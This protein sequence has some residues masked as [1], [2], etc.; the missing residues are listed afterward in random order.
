MSKPRS[1]PTNNLELAK[2]LIAHGTVAP[3]C[4]HP[5]RVLRVAAHILLN[6]NS[7]SRA[8]SALGTDLVGGA[9]GVYITSCVHGTATSADIRA[10]GLTFA[11]SHA[12]ADSSAAA[13]AFVEGAARPGYAVGALASKAKTAAA[14]VAASTTVVSIVLKIFASIG[15]RTAQRLARAA[16][17]DGGCSGSCG[18]DSDGRSNGLGGGG[19]GG[20]NGFGQLRRRGEDGSFSDRDSL[21]Q[22]GGCGNGSSRRSQS[23]ATAGCGNCVTGVA[24]LKSGGC[25]L[26]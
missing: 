11:A 23:Q 3:G 10:H 13:G 25:S 22:G 12:V 5:L 15:C 6:T 16:G 4:E 21:G 2:N 20:E 1:L 17:A 26:A 7:L 18:G 9:V 24:G 19:D 8:A 14:N